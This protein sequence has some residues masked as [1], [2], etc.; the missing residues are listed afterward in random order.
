MRIAPNPGSSRVNQ[1]RTELFE[2]LLLLAVAV[3]AQFIA[4][5]VQQLVPE[6]WRLPVSIV[7]SL[8]P[9]LLWLTLFYVQDRAEPEPQPYVIGV[10]F[11]AGLLAVAI[12]QP[13]IDNVFRTATWIHRDTLTEILGSILVVGVTQELI[14]YLAVRATVYN[15]TEFDERVDGVLYG[16][17]AGVGYATALNLGNALTSGGYDDL[18]AAATRI[19]VTALMHGSVGGL[20]GYFLS[21]QKFNK[22]P[23]LMMPVGLLIAATINGLT[24][25][26]RGELSGNLAALKIDDTGL[27]VA[28]YSP[29]PSLIVSG[30]VALAVFAFVFWR[31][32]RREGRAVAETEGGWSVALTLVVAVAALAAGWLL[33]ET[34]ESRTRGYTDPSGVQINYPERWRLDTRNAQDGRLRVREANATDGFP[35]TLELR[36]VPID[37]SVSPTASVASVA[38]SLAV[39]RGRTQPAF[40]P[41]ALVIDR[42]DANRASLDYV[43]VYVPGSAMQESL[44]VVVLGRDRYLRR[45]DRVYVFSVQST[46]ENLELATRAFDQFVSG[47]VLP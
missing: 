31:M 11:L 9:A 28:G 32:G 19:A 18:A 39:D 21:G 7:A 38:N 41:Y 22:A 37:A 5:G 27:A 34:V 26:L 47:T 12:G 6:G 20:V 25:W 23:A 33:R 35:T 8:I 4:A 15:T 46:E 40:R 2:V 17:A 1:T 30:L 44:P 36:W 29:W 3:A 14:K 10:A 16:S 24:A 43:F 45:G 13:L 42:T